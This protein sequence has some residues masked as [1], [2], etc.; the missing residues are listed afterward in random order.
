MG[1]TIMHLVFLKYVQC[2]K[3]L[4]N[5]CI[6]DQK[7]DFATRLVKCNSHIRHRVNL[8]WQHFLIGIKICYI[9]IF[10]IVLKH[11]LVAT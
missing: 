9:N 4:L 11:I 8:R 10:Y 7:F 6:H 3:L 1:I 5:G 2:S